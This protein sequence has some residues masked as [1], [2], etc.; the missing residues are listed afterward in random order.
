[1]VEIRGC[2]SLG[3][4]GCLPAPMEPAVAAV[5]WPTGG[6]VTA[7][8]GSSS[9]AGFAVPTVATLPVPYGPDDAGARNAVHTHLGMVEREMR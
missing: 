5:P 1:M 7:A 3:D 9:G 6:I 2:G 4:G 8:D